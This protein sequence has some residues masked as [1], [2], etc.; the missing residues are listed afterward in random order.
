MSIFIFIGIVINMCD[1]LREYKYLPCAVVSGSFYVMK[2]LGY[3]IG[4]YISDIIIIREV[5][6]LEYNIENTYIAIQLILHI[7]IIIVFIIY[8]IKHYKNEQIEDE[9]VLNRDS[10]VP[11][12]KEEIKDK[13]ENEK[14][15]KIEEIKEKEEIKERE[16]N[17]EKEEEEE[18]DIIDQED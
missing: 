12:K 5:L 4:G 1:L 7:L 2:G 13:N 9:D 10:Y 17:K 14:I 18:D 3:L 15:K 8:Q 11:L 6:Q 16:E